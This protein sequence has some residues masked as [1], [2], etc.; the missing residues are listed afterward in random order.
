MEIIGNGNP[1]DLEK[2][3]MIYWN[4]AWNWK[5]DDER[6]NAPTPRDMMTVEVIIR[7]KCTALADC[8]DFR[9]AV[10]GGCYG[11]FVTL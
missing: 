3:E 8:L 4:N 10:L 1:K 5:I 6:L 2:R 7:E 11:R 9:G